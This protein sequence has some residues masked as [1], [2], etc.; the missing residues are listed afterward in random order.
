VFTYSSRPAVHQP[1]LVLRLAGSLVAALALLVSLI[2][3]AQPA[4]AQL[5]PPGPCSWTGDWDV[6]LDGSVTTAMHLT[7]SGNSVTGTY[8]LRRGKLLNANA[9]GDI[10]QGEWDHDDPGDD[11]RGSFAFRIDPSCS[12][13]VGTYVVE[14][15]AGRPQGTW[16]GTRRSDTNSQPTAQ[17][18]ISTDRDSYRDGDR[19]QICF[20]IPRDGDLVIT[21]YP[22]G[23]D[24][25]EVVNGFVARG[26]YCI[27]WQAGPGGG[28][29]CLEL[30]FYSTIGD[31]RAYHCFSVT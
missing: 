6:T 31:F 17:P 23:A 14:N 28:R 24:E 13:F 2:G 3:L 19:V 5:P 7:Q 30:Q 26:D 12:S 10:L 27:Q 18:R 11:T 25:V 21:D 1:R 4:A 15:R 9:Q 29:E 16:N 20:S 22:P 8:E